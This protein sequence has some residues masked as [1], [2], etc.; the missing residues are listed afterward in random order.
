MG[1]GGS[2]TDQ[3]IRQEQDT[4]V[5]NKND[6][7]ILN[8]NLNEMVSNSIIND[9]QG[10]SAN[11]TQLQS[12]K[13]SDINIAGDWNMETD[14]TQ[15]SAMTFGC[16]Q[17]LDTRN[18]AANSMIDSMIEQLEANT[19]ADILS[20][21][22]TDALNS[23]ETG[24]LTFGKA[25]AKTDIETI[26]NYEY[27][28]ENTKN[29]ENILKNSVEANFTSNTIQECIAKINQSQEQSFDSIDVGGNANL[30][31]GQ[32]QSAELVANCDQT[33]SAINDVVS[34]VTK[35]LGIETVS[36]TE[37]VQ[38]TDTGVTAETTAVAKGA[39]DELGDA[40]TDVLGGFGDLLNIFGDL[41]PMLIIIGIIGLVGY[42]MFKGV[43]G[44]DDDYSQFMPQQ[45]GYQQMA[46][47]GYPQMGPPSYPQMGPP[48][49]PQMGPPSY[50]QMGYPQY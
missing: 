6:I 3:K 28:T 20:K 42:M 21:M 37:V 47:Q 4:L 16:I 7:N 50:P 8:E 33:R 26:Q 24:A 14:Q 12:I 1:A 2:K 41:L 35:N 48:S 31:F 18:T 39:V 23:A 38:E 9:A 36:A 22:E 15:D 43:I 30:V 29:I 34:D 40:V 13:M 19:S 5:V 10:C 17:A 49:Y 32:S 25:E 11:L 44:G 46:P 45:M 27:R